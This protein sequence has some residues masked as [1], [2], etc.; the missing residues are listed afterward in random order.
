[1][2]YAQYLKALESDAPPEWRG[3]FLGYKRLKKA[4]KILSKDA[5]R[6]DARN[7]VDSAH[8]TP[9]KLPQDSVF[10]TMLH[11]EVLAVNKHFAIEARNLIR[12]AHQGS[13]QKRDFT[14]CGHLGARKP[15]P[16]PPQAKVASV[17]D[18]VVK[19]EWCRR[20]A[21]INAVGLRKILKKHDK[22]CKNK[23]GNTYMQEL[24]CGVKRMDG[25]F[26]HSPLLEELKS[27][28]VRLVRQA[29]RVRMGKGSADSS[30]DSS[31]R[32]A[33]GALQSVHSVSVDLPVQGPAVAETVELPM[34]PSINSG[35]AVQHYAVSAKK[36]VTAPSD[37]TSEVARAVSAT[38]RAIRK[39]LELSRISVASS[40]VGDQQEA[41]PE[42]QCPICLEVMYQPLGLECGHKFCADCVFTC[43]GKGRALGT[44]K[45]I[46]DHVPADS[47]CP[48][49]RTPGVFVAAIQ[50]TE[51]ENLIKQRYPQAWAERA[52]EARKKEARLRELL[53]IQRAVRNDTIRAW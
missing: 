18:L 32:A 30:T 51:T 46:L 15:L 8:S 19:A 14:C 20:Y 35:S 44:V 24:W 16:R 33:A 13:G 40:G 42:Y 21:Q 34:L 31:R 4:I 6:Q 48:E 52:E 45:A 38:E 17:D 39:E 22:L 10:F 53:A 36:L 3:K 5:D 41:D 28:E 37:A 25:T 27:L 1:M 23:L 12:M 2:K 7:G 11:R 26:L 50:L 47:A 9:R 49:C 43:V 29:Y